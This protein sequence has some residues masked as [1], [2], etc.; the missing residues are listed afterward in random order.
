MRKGKQICFIVLLAVLIVGAVIFITLWMM[1]ASERKH[2][3][4]KKL[5]IDTDSGADDAAALILAAKCEDVELLG[6]T[7]LLGNADL[8]QGTKNTL[9][10]LEMAGCDAPVFKGSDTS[11]SGKPISK[12]GVFGEDGM[13]DA[14]LIHPSG[15]PQ[16]QDAVSFILDTVAANPGEV[17][18]IALGPATNIAKAIQKDPET[19]KQVKRIWTMGTAGLGPGNASPVAEFNAYHDIEAYR[20]LLDAGIP[21]TIVGLDVCGGD[22]Q[23]TSAQ[24][25][26]LAK[27]ND[28]GKFIA[29]A[30]GKLREFY[31]ANGSPDATNNCD[32]VAMMCCLDPTFTTASVQAHGS[33]ITQEGET[34]GQV[35]FYQ[36]GFTYDDVKN[37]FAYNVTLTTEVDRGRFF[38]QYYS[39]ITS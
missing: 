7:T 19:M 37:D 3:P 26:K 25:D 33:C 32:T 22:A 27:A 21:V 35:L 28:I 36:K 11:Y 5:I 31:A 9:M 20:V 16:E 13:G 34:Y 17:E 8:E 15:T 2:F 38:D 1:G 10:S 24:F 18:I 14:G 12:G 39:I 23:W 30:F 6:V 4:P 29:D